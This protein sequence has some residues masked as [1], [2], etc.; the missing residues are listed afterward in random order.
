MMWILIMITMALLVLAI[1]AYL[2]SRVMHFS[3]LLRLANGSKKRLAVYAALIALFVIV[4]LYLSLDLINAAIVLLHLGIFWILFDLAAFVIRKCRKSEPAHASVS[5]DPSQSRS[6]SHPI[7]WPGICA[8]VIT[9]LY[10]AYGWVSAFHV[11]KT[12]YTLQTDKA[13][14]NLRVVGFADSHVGATFDRDGF[15]KHVEAMQACDPDIVIL[16]GDYVDDETM[17]EDMIAS[18]EA[19]GTLKTTYGVYFVF[20]NHDK[21]YYNN[22]HRGFD[23]D[24]LIAELEKNNVTVLQD[25]T[26]L[27]DDRLY[28]IGRQDKSEEDFRVGRAPM[29]Q[30]VEGLDTSKYMIVMDHQPNDYDAEEAAGV[31]LVFSGHTHGGQFLPI[32]RLGEW[33]GLNDKTYG[34]ERRGATDFIV[35]SGIAD[36]AIKFKTGCI[37]EFV[38]MDITG[39]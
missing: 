16:S 23:A 14:G 30:L 26:V 25:E 36:W 7:Y 35:T 2:T 33:A 15:R 12:T 4:N 32:N 28:L 13:V 21:G 1:L 5:P 9:V 27:L 24:D 37:S 8:V 29:D 22:E 17:R 10:M 3:I 18:C 39:A 38:I 19:L 20:G 34:Y 6:A 31:D 11:S